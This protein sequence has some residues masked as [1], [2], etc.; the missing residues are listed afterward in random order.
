[1]LA[2]TQEFPDALKRALLGRYVLEREL[3]RGGMAIVYGAHD[4]RHDRP[5]AIKV[6]LPELAAAIGAERFLAE[7]HT[8]AKLQHPHILPLFDSGAA[9]GQ[10]YYVMPLVEGES[11]RERL[12]REGPLAVDQVARL[13]GEVGSALDYAHRHGVIHRDIKPANILLHEGNAMLADFGI[14]R[15]A[16]DSSAERLTETGLSIGTPQ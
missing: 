16:A 11:L 2:S 14:A 3:G 5:V 9:E 7:I 4:V 6:L 1:L 13:V 8:T 12:A 15:A 10:L